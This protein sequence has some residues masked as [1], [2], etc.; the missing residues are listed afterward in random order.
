MPLGVLITG[1]VKQLICEAVEKSTRPQLRRGTGCARPESVVEDLKP[2]DLCLGSLKPGENWDARAAKEWIPNYPLQ[3]LGKPE[4]IAYG[5][6]FLA[7]DEA[8]WISGTDLTIDGGMMA[9][10]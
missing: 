6:L 3:R 9:R 5:A 10:L 2:D 8:G 7:S 1:E 4:D